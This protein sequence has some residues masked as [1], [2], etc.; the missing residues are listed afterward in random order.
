MS[1]KRGAK[2]SNSWHPRGTKGAVATR[3]R[4]PPELLT[5]LM[6][7]NPGAIGQRNRNGA[8]TRLFAPFIYKNARFFTKT[9]SGQT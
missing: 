5:A 6:T 2:Q 4:P 7:A 3:H 1:F 9:G 8:E